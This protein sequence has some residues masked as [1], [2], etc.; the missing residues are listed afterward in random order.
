LLQFQAAQQAFEL[1]LLDEA[2]ARL[3]RHAS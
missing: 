3:R 1:R 2:G